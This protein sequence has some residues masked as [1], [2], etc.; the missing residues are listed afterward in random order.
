MSLKLFQESEDSEKL[1]PAPIM[2]FLLCV[3]PAVLEE[4]AVASEVVGA[5]P[6]SADPHHGVGVLP[7]SQH[8]LQR[9][10]VGPGCREPRHL[11]AT[12]RQ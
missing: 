3:D 1:L 11:S 12:L 6:H 7:R 2:S 4:L 8:R 5:V 9:L 10:A